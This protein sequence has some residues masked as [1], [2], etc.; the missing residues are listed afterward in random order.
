MIKLL[1]RLLKN[2]RV[3]SEDKN[4][5]LNYLLESINALPIK[6]LISYDL[7]GTMLINGKKLTPEQAIM[8]REGAISMEKNWTY[9]TIKEQIAFEAVKIGIH[10]G[11]NVE[12]I[13]FAKVALWIQT[14]EIELL[15]KISGSIDKDID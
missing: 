5:I 13:M 6:D 15:N 10:L 14:K 8:L 3:N 4:L 1:I 2:K 11:N 7:D 12:Q 9:R